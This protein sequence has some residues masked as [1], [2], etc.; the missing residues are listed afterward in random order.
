M[1]MT[2]DK[3]YTYT[4]V[5]IAERFIIHFSKIANRAMMYY[6]LC[7]VQDVYIFHHSNQWYISD[8]I[9]IASL[10]PADSNTNILNRFFLYVLKETKETLTFQ[11]YIKLK[12]FNIWKNVLQMFFHSVYIS[13][14]LFSQTRP[15]FC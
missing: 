2:F 12:A 11:H 9:W 5:H 15:I 7:R 1:K 10:G 6:W 3:P 14:K 4:N 13:S 8:A